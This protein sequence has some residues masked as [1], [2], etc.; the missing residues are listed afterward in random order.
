MVA[1]GSR[2][3]KP[4]IKKNKMDQEYCYIPRRTFLFG[5]DNSQAR[6]PGPL[7]M[8]KEPISNVDFKLF[9]DQTGYDY[10]LF[11]VMIQLSPEP[12]CPA[13]PVSWNDAKAY[14]RWISEMT[15]GY[16]DLPS[17][18]AWEIAARGVDGRLYPWGNT[19]PT[20][21]HGIF[22]LKKYRKFTNVSSKFPLNI[23]HFGCVNMVGNVWE[24]CSEEVII[25]DDDADSDGD[26]D[27]ESSEETTEI[28]HILRGGSCIDSH[29]YCNCVTQRIEGPSDKR[30]LYAGFRLIHLT[31]DM[32][33][34]YCE[35]D[36]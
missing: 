26:E 31:P 3:D 21:K 7:Y 14:A 9:V 24:W 33:A 11:D 29:E 30:V 35:M 12:G 23:S 6:M 18:E 32:Y 1:Q 15:G 2:W 4:I 28:S 34:K 8:A 10:K 36:E 27:S 22:S 5:E 17:Q 13:T 25:E 19:P 16:Y 20:D